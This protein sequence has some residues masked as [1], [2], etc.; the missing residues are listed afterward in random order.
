MRRLLIATIT[1]GLAMGAA[2]PALAGAPV[3]VTG[4]ENGGICVT[5][6]DQVTQCL[7]LGKP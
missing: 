7:D 3:T 4:H 5:V 6:D 2:A 1:T